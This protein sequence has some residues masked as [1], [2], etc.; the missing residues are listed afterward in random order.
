MI[1]CNLIYLI[2][3]GINK[4]EC[5]RLDNDLLNYVL[6]EIQSQLNKLCLIWDFKQ[7]TYLYFIIKEVP[8]LT[9]LLATFLE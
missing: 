3:Y 9:K 4:I 5:Y 8:K 2:T 6:K 7:Y 1:N